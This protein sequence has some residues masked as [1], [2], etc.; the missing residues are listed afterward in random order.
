MRE[1]LRVV[2]EPEQVSA[3]HLVVDEGAFVNLRDEL[4]PANLLRTIHD[5]EDTST[6]YES[7]PALQ[8]RSAVSQEA[9]SRAAATAAATAAVA[10]C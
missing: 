6:F 2:A 8:L 3:G 9:H 1:K 5:S 7:A 4:L 10:T